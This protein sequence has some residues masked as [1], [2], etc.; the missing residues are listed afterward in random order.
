MESRPQKTWGGLLIWDVA[1]IS[2]PLVKKAEDRAPSLPEDAALQSLTAT[3]QDEREVPTPL[4][5]T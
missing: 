1:T 2:G 5:K 3:S 4:N